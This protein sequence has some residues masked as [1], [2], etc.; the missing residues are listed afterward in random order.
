MAN[1]HSNCLLGI[2]CTTAEKK[3]MP[4]HVTF[5]LLGNISTALAE[6]LM[7]V[8]TSRLGDYIG[9][10]DDELLTEV[11]KSISVALGLT[12][13]YTVPTRLV[14]HNETKNEEINDKE[15]IQ[16]ESKVE[17]RGRKPKFTLED[18]IRFVN[19]YENHDKEYMKKKYNIN[20]DKSLINKVYLFRKAIKENS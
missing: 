9:T 14:I 1:K 2:P 16:D 7:S 13:I 18:K 17:T 12:D 3:E 10:M 20:C 19:D 5:D 4:T 8:N 6:N 11:E 15:D